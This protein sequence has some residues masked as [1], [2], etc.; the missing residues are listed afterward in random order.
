MTYLKANTVGFSFVAMYDVAH[1]IISLPRKPME[2]CTLI[3]WTLFV[4][5][6][7]R[8]IEF[9]TYSLQY[10]IKYLYFY[11]PFGLI[12]HMLPCLGFS[13][14]KGAVMRKSRVHVMTAYLWPSCTTSIWEIIP[15]PPP[16]PPPPFHWRLF[17]KLCPFDERSPLVRLMCWSQTDDRAWPMVPKLTSAY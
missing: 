16:P 11:L 17:L 13:V 9:L 10:R 12:S 8:N 4:A 1:D 7:R 3:T 15:P 14:S 5:T 6:T 2:S